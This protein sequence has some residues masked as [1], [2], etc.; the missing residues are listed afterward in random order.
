PIMKKIYFKGYLPT[1]TSIITIE[2]I[3]AVVEKLA[4]RINIKVMK[5]GVHNSHKEDLK[6]IGVSLVFDK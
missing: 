1:K 6:V 3:K 2:K 5:T 4:G